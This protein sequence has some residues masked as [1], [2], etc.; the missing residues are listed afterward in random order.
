MTLWHYGQPL[1]FDKKIDDWSLR[2]LIRPKMD[3]LMLV[4]ISENKLYY[5]LRYWKGAQTPWTTPQLVSNMPYQGQVQALV[6]I[7]SASRNYLQIAVQLTDNRIDML[8]INPGDLK[9]IQDIE[10]QDPP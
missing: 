4:F 9:E 10:G 1:I 8:W 3:Y 2:E 6:S 7:R 5:S